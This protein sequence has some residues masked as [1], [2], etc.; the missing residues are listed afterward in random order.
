[1]VESGAGASLNEPPSELE[2][3]ALNFLATFF[4]RHLTE[5]L[6]RHT[7]ARAQKIYPIRDMRP[8]NIREAL[9]QPRGTGFFPPALVESFSHQ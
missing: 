8:L 7:S 9:P 4:S 3:L 2:Q 1:L 6:N 5:Q